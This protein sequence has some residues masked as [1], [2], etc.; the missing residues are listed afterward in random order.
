MCSLPLY[1][2]S[3]K[4]LIELNGELYGAYKI[5]QHALQQ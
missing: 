3:E 5:K 4:N 1:T 2:S